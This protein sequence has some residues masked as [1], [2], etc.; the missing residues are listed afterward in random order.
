MHVPPATAR[1]GALAVLATALVAGC[2]GGSA[3]AAGPSTPPTLFTPSPC[4]TPTAATKP[5]WPKTMPADIPK[6]TY[7]TVQ[8]T[9]RTPDGVAVTRYV[10]PTSLRESVLF[11]VSAYPKAGYVLGRGDAESTEADAPFVHGD[12]RG[13]TR[14]SML[15]QC[16]TLWLTATVK[17]TSPGGGS[18]LL[19]SHTPSG[20]PSPLPFG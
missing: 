11:I 17:A 18:P 12:V 5:V 7:A 8:Q 14:I 16:Q 9:T 1:L 15:A 4:P 2:S 6:P 19:P 3:P 13:V 20:S 10:T